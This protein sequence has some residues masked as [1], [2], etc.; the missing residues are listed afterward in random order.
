MYGVKPDSDV[1]EA[2][3]DAEIQMQRLRAKKEDTHNKL[4]EINPLII[5][6]FNLHQGKSQPKFKANNLLLARSSEHEVLKSRE[7]DLGLRYSTND[8]KG[9][10]LPAIKKCLEENSNFVLDDYGQGFLL[11]HRGWRL[12]SS[13][14]HKFDPSTMNCP[15]PISITDGREW[16]DALY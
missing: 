6:Q 9:S 16:W 3:D 13:Y 8:F 1:E 12:Q 4:L 15:I 14:F 5:L 7:F 2:E 11:Y 10:I